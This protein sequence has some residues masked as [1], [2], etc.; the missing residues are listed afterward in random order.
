MSGAARRWL[1]SFGYD[2]SGFDGWARQPG[3]RTVEGVLLAGLARSGV[4]VPGAPPRLDVASRTDRGVSAR[5]NALVMESRLEPRALLRAMN[6]IAPEILFREAWPVDD[7]FRPRRALAREYR[8]YET[9]RERHPDR[10]RAVLPLFSGRTIDVRSFGRAIPSAEPSWRAL[11]RVDLVEEEDHLR[12]DL[13][14]P[15]FVWGMVRKIVSAFRAVDAGAISVDRLSAALEGRARLGLPL[16]EPEPLV[17]WEVDYGLPPGIQSAR[18][19][20]RHAG[21][22][23]AEREAAGLRGPLLRAV[24]DG[25][26]VPPR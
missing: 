22:F 1:L 7:G 24:T 9:R 25:A 12:L 16:A 20:A 23:E 3:R 4:G 14:A 2:G 17:L 21:Y 5:A 10:W 19:S 26:P 13:R 18:M 6:G 15:A 11:S 8:Y